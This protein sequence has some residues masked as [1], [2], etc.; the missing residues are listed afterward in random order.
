MEQESQGGIPHPYPCSHLVRRSSSGPA[1]RHAQDRNFLIT[2]ARVGRE[3]GGTAGWQR[4]SVVRTQGK[5]HLERR[6]P[7]HGLDQRTEDSRF[8]SSPTISSRDAGS[9]ARQLTPIHA[10]AH[11]QLQ[12]PPRI[13]ST[14]RPPEAHLRHAWDRHCWQVTWAG[15][16]RLPFHWG[17]EMGLSSSDWLPAL[18][19]NCKAIY[20]PLQPELQM[21]CSEST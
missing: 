13:W 5:G 12:P 15:R 18:L 2:A 17:V 19:R 8:D 3:G 9:D 7:M 6:G 16:P 4:P 21:Q 20:S 11:S 10:G 14:H 1:V